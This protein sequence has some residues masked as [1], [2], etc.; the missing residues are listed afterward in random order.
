M[1]DQNEIPILLPG[2]AN[3]FAVISYTFSLSNY[4]ALLF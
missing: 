3:I 2:S 4:A 1:G